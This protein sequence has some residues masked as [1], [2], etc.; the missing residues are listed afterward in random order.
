MDFLQNVQLP[1]YLEDALAPLTWAGIFS[2]QFRDDIVT[3]ILCPSDS[4]EEIIKDFL[5]SFNTIM[6]LNAQWKEELRAALIKFGQEG[7]PKSC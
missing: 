7:F 3:C 4:R 5:K 6:F 2:E 1:Q